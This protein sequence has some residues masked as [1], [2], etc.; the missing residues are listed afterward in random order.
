MIFA[1][2]LGKNMQYLKYEG[3]GDHFIYLVEN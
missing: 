3:L 2:V 1:D